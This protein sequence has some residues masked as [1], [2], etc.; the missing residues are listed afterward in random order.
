M[1]IGDSDDGGA[2]DQPARLVNQQGASARALRSYH[3][4]TRV[5]H[6]EAEAWLGLSQRLFRRRTPRPFALLAI[7]GTACAAAALWWVNRPGDLTAGA[8]GPGMATP[9]IVVAP[10]NERPAA[11]APEPTLP[12]LE[13]TTAPRSVP[14]GPSQIVNRTHLAATQGT[15][16]VARTVGGVAE[17]A[18]TSGAL[19][20]QVATGASGQTR[21]VAGIYTF[22]DVGTRFAVTRNAGAVAL[23]V[24]EGIVE[25][26]HG[27]RLLAIVHG[28]RGI[29]TG[30]G[31]DEPSPAGGRGPGRGQSTRPSPAAPSIATS[32]PPPSLSPPPTT[33]PPLAT[34][35]PPPPSSS[36]RLP[37]P[38]TDVA[39]A[40]LCLDGR[41]RGAG[42]AA[43]SA[44]YEI[45]RLKRD[46]LGDSAGAIAALEQHRRRFPTGQLRIEVGL[47]L[48]DLLPRV[49]RHREALRDSAALLA[50]NPRLE[51]ADELR[52]LRGNIY[53]EGLADCASALREYGAVS[54][55]AGR[56]SSDSLFYQSAC[57]DQ[58]GRRDEA[59]AGYRAYLDLPDAS[60][61][62]DARQRLKTLGP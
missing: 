33:A 39:P 55:D 5:R 16:A 14:A 38:G 13:L 45:A 37:T 19:D 49:G 54:R 17:I 41:A 48:V 44:L 26:R 21:V 46:R 1:N 30:S 32:A 31:S 23:S 57:L 59:R 6:G 43:E 56:I 34:T 20:V 58:L 25:V 9:T 28:P 47:S 7:A 51:R 61:A 60:R 22:I 12:E 15:R 62:D 36:C 8:A 29:W 2:A 40:L 24:S 50:D 10:G 52:L 53:R 35:A 27:K 18:L 42:L 3:V 11:P 4:S